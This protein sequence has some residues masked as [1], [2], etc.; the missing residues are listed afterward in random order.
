MKYLNMKQVTDMPVHHQLA[1]DLW[2]ESREKRIDVLQS[3]A[4]EIVLMYVDIEARFDNQ[5]ELECDEEGSHIES[6]DQV[7]SYA[8]GLLSMGLIYMEFSDAI[9]EGDGLRILRCWRYLM[10]IFKA[11]QRSNYSIEALNLLSQ[12]HFFFTFRQAEQ[13]I[14]SRCV[15]THGRPGKNIPCDLYMEHLNRICKMTVA[16][17]GA[18]KTTDSLQRAAKCVGVLAKLLLKYDDDMGIS[19]RSG[20]HYVASMSKDKRIVIEQLLDKDVFAHVDNRKHSCF[21][22][23]RRNIMSKINKKTLD[24]WMKDQLQILQRTLYYTQSHA[25]V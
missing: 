20:N 13:L 10:L 19:E 4:N 2:V 18:N 15:N 17:L 22:S 23:I 11:A 24:N 16:H 6:D 9:R 8:S 21:G 1:E 14:W 3:V 7:Q 12:Y 25:H 5:A